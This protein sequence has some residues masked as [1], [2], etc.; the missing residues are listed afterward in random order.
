MACFCVVV[1]EPSGAVK[2]GEFLDYLRKSKGNRPS[3]RLDDIIKTDMQG[4]G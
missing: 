4:I 3:R 2:Y 1:N